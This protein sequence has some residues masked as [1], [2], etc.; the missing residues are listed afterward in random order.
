M[1]F[2]DL[3]EGDKFYI[4]DVNKTLLEAVTVVQNKFNVIVVESKGKLVNIKIRNPNNNQITY[5]KNTG[6][7]R[8]LRVNE[9][10]ETI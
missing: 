2:R 7:K 9:I 3:K 6:E 5:I 1:A 8:F 10:G 4:Y